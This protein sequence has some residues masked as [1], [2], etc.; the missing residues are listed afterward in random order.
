M[1]ISHTSFL[2]ILWW[3]LIYQLPHYGQT[4]FIAYEV[5]QIVCCDTSFRYFIYVEWSLLLEGCPLA[6]MTNT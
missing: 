5:R 1:F 2:I 4:R 3:L 6:T